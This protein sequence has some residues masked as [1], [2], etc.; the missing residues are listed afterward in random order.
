MLGCEANTKGKTGVLASF[1]CSMKYL[2]YIYR[3]EYKQ[4]IM[5]RAA[6]IARRAFFSTKGMGIEPHVVFT[7]SEFKQFVQ[8]LT[9]E[10]RIICA[11]AAR[12]AIAHPLAEAQIAGEVI[13]AC[14]APQI[15]Q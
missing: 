14:E 9:A 11:Q 7:E 1:F 5:G 4:V 3:M 12:D 6:N 10:Q 8:Y 13:E 2:E 15:F